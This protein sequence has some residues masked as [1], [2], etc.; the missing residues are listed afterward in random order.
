MPEAVRAGRPRSVSSEAILAEARRQLAAGG[1]SDFSVRELAKA[2][3]IVPGTI[4]ARFGNKHELLAALYLQRI[5]EAEAVLAGLPDRARGV[6]SLLD[7]IAPSLSTLRREYVLHFEGD[8]HRGPHLQPE[9][10]SAL[11]ASFRRLSERLYG[12]FRTA[13]AHEGITVVDGSKARRLVWTAASTLDSP[14]G[15]A[16]FHH[17]DPGYRRFVATSLLRALATSG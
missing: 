3:G 11:E 7:A 8:R 12:R 10:W 14:R 16:A 2:L 9:T 13:A 15:A 5:G 6:G 1:V 17:T 4:H